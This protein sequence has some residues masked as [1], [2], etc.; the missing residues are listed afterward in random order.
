MMHTAPMC[1]HANHAEP[2]NSMDPAKHKNW[3]QHRDSSHEYQPPR[4]KDMYVYVS[5]RCL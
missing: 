3:H 1:Q 5:S 2:S 4:S